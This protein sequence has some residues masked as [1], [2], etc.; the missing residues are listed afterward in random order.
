MARNLN[1]K[2]GFTLLELV[3][4]MGIFTVLVGGVLYSSF[5]LQELMQYNSIEY[6]TKE[7]IYRHLTVLQEFG[8]IATGI[9]IGTSSLK[10]INMNGYVE[11]VLENSHIH[12]KF[13]H[14]DGFKIEF[15]E[16]PFTK[17]EEFNFKRADRQDTFF[18]K[19]VLQI[20]AMRKNSKNKLVYLVDFLL[21]P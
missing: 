19:C 8:K 12:L 11:Q 10:L 7:Q 5:Y 13:V 17:F 20:E 21:I 1:C 9:E 6:K 18:T 16:L 3:L 15:T 2:K 14:K 4:Y